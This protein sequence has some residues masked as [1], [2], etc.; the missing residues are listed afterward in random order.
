MKR[1]TAAAIVLF[2]L[3][4]LTGSAQ[5][6]ENGGFVVIVHPDNPIVSLTADEV[7]AIFLKQTD[8]WLDGA[9]T[10]PVNL[11]AQAGARERFSILIHGREAS[12]IQSFWRQQVFSGEAAPPLEVA[13]E[14]EMLR[15]VAANRGA[16]GYVGAGTEIDGVSILNIMNPP[17]RLSF[18]APRYP[19]RARRARARG[20]V[21]LDLT[22]DA[23]GNVAAVSPVNELG[24]GLTDEAVMA[25]RKWKYRP[26]TR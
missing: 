22:I 23:E 12:R 21:S 14:A 17:E 9:A 16:I 10:Y 5:A 8:S 11:G 19:P 7:S 3:M 1:N 26:A 2:A 6:Q 25:A 13:D 15:T 20:E 4:T 24:F 18:V